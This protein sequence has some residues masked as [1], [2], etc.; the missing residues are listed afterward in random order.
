MLGWSDNRATDAMV[1]RY[2]FAG[3]NATA[4]VAGM[5]NSHVYHRIG[6]PGAA[7]PQPWHHNNLTL[8]DAGKIYEGVENGNLLDSTR[9]NSLYGWLVGG[10]ISSGTPLGQMIQQEAA[11]AGLTATEISSFLANTKSLS[12]GG[13]YDMCPDTGSCNAPVYLSRTAGGTIWVPFKSGGVITKQAYVWGRFFNAQFNCT[14]ASVKAGTCAGLNNESA[15]MG[16]IGV[17]MYRAVIKQAL[18]T[19]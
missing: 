4:A 6:C 1:N 8:R 10:T 16:T 15:G 11:A 9:K 3:L 7:S 2:G 19:W 12:K 13:S 5:T 14:F 17:E 18:A